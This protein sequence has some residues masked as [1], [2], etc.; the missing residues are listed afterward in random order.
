MVLT[1]KGEQE[2]REQHEKA[3]AVGVRR[4]AV[5]L[6]LLTDAHLNFD[7]C[8]VG[9]RGH[10]WVSDEQR[11]LVVGFLQTVQKR[12]LGVC[13]CGGHTEG[14]GSFFN[15]WMQVLSLHSAYTVAHFCKAELN[16]C[17]KMQKKTYMPQVSVCQAV[18][19]NWGHRNWHHLSCE[20]SCYI[21]LHH[22]LKFLKRHMGK[23]LEPVYFM[24]KCS[25]IWK[26]AYF[27]G[28]QWI[29]P[30][31]RVISVLYL[32]RIIYIAKPSAQDNVTRQ[33]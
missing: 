14:E 20:L 10:P 25:T 21:L 9:Q 30:T 5:H 1:E 28:L 16:M 33:Q 8:A 22:T 2:C 7:L 19:D 18:A 17:I 12:D 15:K 23:I 24:L 26:A 4:A 3:D 29:L 6:V 31:A 32:I 27:T 11:E 13:G